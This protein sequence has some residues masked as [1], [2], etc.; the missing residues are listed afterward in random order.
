[1]RKRVGEDPGNPIDDPFDILKQL[2]RLNDKNWRQF[3][4]KRNLPDY[5][6]LLTD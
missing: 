1:M 6:A 4:P 3:S 2:D 5:V